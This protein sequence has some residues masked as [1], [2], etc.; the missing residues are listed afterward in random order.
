MLKAMMSTFERD[1][2]TSERI[3]G[4]KLGLNSTTLHHTPY[5]QE[6]LN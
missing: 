1:P 2:E 6:T 4:A 5:S 3:F